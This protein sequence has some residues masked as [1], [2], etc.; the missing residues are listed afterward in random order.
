MKRNTLTSI[1]LALCRQ[2][3][4]TMVDIE[5]MVP[6]AI[7]GNR[8]MAAYNLVKRGQLRNLNAGTGRAVPGLYVTKGYESAGLKVPSPRPRSSEPDPLRGWR[9]TRNADPA[10]TLDLLPALERLARAYRHATGREGA[11]T[12]ALLDAEK[13]I[14]QARMSRTPQETRP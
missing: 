8:K 6:P 5:E 12:P 14:A 7:S 4:R 9:Q 10:R 3:P 1:I 13:A 11:D 2:C